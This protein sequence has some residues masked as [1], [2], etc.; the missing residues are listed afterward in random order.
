MEAPGGGMAA[1][2]MPDPGKIRFRMRDTSD[3]LYPCSAVDSVYQFACYQL[4]GGI[5]LDR[6]R[7][8]FARATTACD[9]VGP[10][11]LRAQC[12]LS[13][14]TNAS[15][16]TLRNTDQSIRDCSHGDPAYQP[17]CFEGV[18]KNFVDVTG[19]P[20]DG[21][22]FCAAVPHGVNRMECYIA[23]GEEIAVLYVNDPAARATACR[24]AG[25]D[26]EADCRRGADLPTG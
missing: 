17:Y 19:R 10:P 7:G 2:P 8:D 13:L 14:G 1:M 3:M 9:R 11:L 25:V 22:E 18:A 23:V 21:F 26:G 4:Q 5:I 24:A 16:M 6:T 15:G 20:G 12:Y